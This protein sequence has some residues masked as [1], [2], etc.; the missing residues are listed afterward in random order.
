MDYA[1]VLIKMQ[2]GLKELHD[3]INHK[4]WL[5]VDIEADNLVFLAKQMRDSVADIHTK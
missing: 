5:V 2:A 1:E 4:D 3:A